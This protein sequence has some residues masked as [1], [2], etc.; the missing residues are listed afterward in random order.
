MLS[1]ELRTTLIVAACIVGAALL[2]LIVLR[3]RR[4]GWLNS[5]K[6]D[7]SGLRSEKPT[8]VTQTGASSQTTVP[9][10]QPVAAATSVKPLPK[11]EPAD[12]PGRT[13]MIF[14]GLTPLF[15]SMLPESDDK[16]RLMK[17][18]LANAGYYQ[19]NAWLNLA[20][21][22]YLGI[23]LPILFFGILFLIVPP[24]MELFVLLAGV[25]VVMLGWAVP[26]LMVRSRA[27]ERRDEIGK[28]MPD[29][30][31]MLNMCVSQGMTLPN[32]LNRVSYEL[33]P[34][35]PALSQE[36]AIVTDQA[37]V[38]SME[39]A[40]QNFADRVDVPEV[41]SFTS[42]LIQTE[43]MGTSV[44]AALADH[45][46]NIRESQKQRADQAANMATFKLLFPTALCLMPAVFLILLGPAL[47]DLSDFFSGEAGEAF[48]NN[49]AAAT[50]TLQEYGVEDN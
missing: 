48:R 47:V 28:A 2:A 18:E 35:Y 19:P 14:G 25:A 15:A 13:D 16:K 24:A 41:H 21:I 7:N 3:R 38:G 40:L 34:V 43:K 49:R 20:A 46:D 29:M 12:V 8:D 22:R 31:D 4:S 37:K 50:Q 6:S 5:L 9:T 26:S 1:P 10:A 23:I 30:L 39:Q 33:K 32:S 17:R 36:L 45:S 44:S 11:V 27:A 42:T